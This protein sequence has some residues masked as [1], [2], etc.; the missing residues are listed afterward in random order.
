M[1]IFIILLD[2]RFRGNDGSH[3][4]PL[5]RLRGHRFR[6]ND[7]KIKK[8]DGPIFNERSFNIYVSNIYNMFDTFFQYVESLDMF[9]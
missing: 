2:S 6:G 9:F 5:R 8:G 1:K 7:G 3:G 4:F